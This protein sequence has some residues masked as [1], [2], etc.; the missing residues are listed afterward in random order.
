MEVGRCSYESTISYAHTLC[1]RDPLDA[2]ASPDATS[3]PP[4]DPSYALQPKL[5]SVLLFLLYLRSSLPFCYRISPV[6]LLPAH[7]LAAWCF[8]R[9]MRIEQ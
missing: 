5:C 8:S 1:P 2:H 7:Q 3:Q 6:P 9:V 4:L